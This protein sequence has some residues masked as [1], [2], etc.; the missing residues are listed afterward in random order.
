MGRLRAWGSRLAF[1]E[2]AASAVSDGEDIVILGGLKGKF[3]SPKLSR[4][5]ISTPRVI[6]SSESP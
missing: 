1:V 6:E 2:N 5:N 3:S 4:M